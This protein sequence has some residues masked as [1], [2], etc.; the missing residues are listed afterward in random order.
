[1]IR[2]IRSAGDPAFADAYALLRRTFPR[3]ELLPRRDWQDVLRE[4]DA[5]VW[6]DLNWHLLVAVRRGAVI[7]A[8]SGTYLGNLNVG[9]IGYVAVDAAVRSLGLGPR[10]RRRLRRSMHAD[11]RRI[12]RRPLAALVGEVRADNPWLRHLVRHYGAIALD[13]PYVQ[14]SLRPRGDDVALVLYYQPL[15]GARRSLPATKVRRLL[16]GIWRRYYRVGKPL[17]RPGFR[18]MLRALAGRR[19]I[20]QHPAGRARRRAAGVIE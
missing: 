2:E 12:I 5:G 8:A 6:T 1:V 9:I 18:R 14:P 11:A 13:I 19:Q 16:Y 15:T 7:G 17:S 3:D 4:R 20:G 10:L